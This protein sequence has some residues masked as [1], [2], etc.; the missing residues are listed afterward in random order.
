MWMVDALCAQT[1][2][3]VFHP[4]RGESARPAKSVCQVCEVRVP[5]LAY[6]LEHREEHGVW[7]GLSP[8][9][10]RVITRPSGH[11]AK[12]ALR[13]GAPNHLQ[14]SGEI[15]MVENVSAAR[16]EGEVA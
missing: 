13:V 1:D 8:N 15:P 12:N 5:C 11:S 9:E 4:D 10:R 7:G 6:A 3:E 16:V 2:P 14:G